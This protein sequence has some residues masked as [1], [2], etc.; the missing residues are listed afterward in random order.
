MKIKITILCLALTLISCYEDLGNY[1]YQ[2]L[3]TITVEGI[4]ETYT[5]NTRID[6]LK[7]SPIIEASAVDAEMEYFWLRRSATLN[8]SKWDTTFVG[9]NLDTLVTWAP[10]TSWEFLFVARNKKTS[11]AVHES[12]RLFIGTP[13]MYG[14]YVAKSNGSH[15]DLDFYPFKNDPSGVGALSPNVIE[16]INGVEK[17]PRGDAQKVNFIGGYPIYSY[18][19]GTTIKYKTLQLITD[20]DCSVVSVE[21]IQGMRKYEEMFYTFPEGSKPAFVGC[22]LE[23][24][25]MV[26]EKHLYTFYY[27]G[28][29][30]NGK[31]NHPKRLPSGASD[32]YNYQISKYIHYNMRNN[33]VFDEISSSFFRFTDSEAEFIRLKDGSEKGEPTQIPLENNNKTLLYM[34]TRSVFERTPGTASVFLQDK[35]NPNL[36]IL[37]KLWVGDRD[38]ISLIQADTLNPAED[39]LFGAEHVTHASGEGLYFI[40]KQKVY[41]RATAIKDSE[42]VLVYEI[43]EAETVSFIRT[44]NYNRSGDALLDI[45]AIG[46]TLDGS[47][48][49]VRLFGKTVAGGLTEEPLYTLPATG[50]FAPGEAKDITY[51][52]LRLIDMYNVCSW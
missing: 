47:Q 40:N 20:E 37:C 29:S 5:L 31:V 13:F 33:I 14:L 7:I 11:Y 46:S 50:G 26:D 16:A 24:Y 36:K 18:D 38:H 39:A 44:I 22:S 49:K 45:L 35:T 9:L 10:N 4:E 52:T 42:E 21:D 34:G 1:D 3:E 17:C 23:D 12:F 48:Y 6:T 41:Y 27:M 30:S 32:P 8:T 51:I 28:R 15:S 25:F 43:P 2:E 19:E